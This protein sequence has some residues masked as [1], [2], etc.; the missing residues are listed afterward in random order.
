[1]GPAQGAPQAGQV[2]ARVA[3]QQAHQAVQPLARLHVHREAQA[4]HAGTTVSVGYKRTL[5]FAISQYAWHR[6]TWSL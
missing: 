2:V 4:R 5:F 6:Y 1:M 3:E